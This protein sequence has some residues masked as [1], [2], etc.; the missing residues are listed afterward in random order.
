MEGIELFNR[1]TEEK[2]KI[3]EIGHKRI[4]GREGGVEVVVE[5]ISK[6]LVAKGYKV[7]VYD[8]SGNHVSGAEFNK[9]AEKEDYGIN[10]I[11]IP[12]IQKKGFAA[13]VYSLIASVYASCKGY[14]VIHYHSEGPCAFLWIPSLFGIRTVAT[15]HGLDWQRTGKWGSFAS[16]FIK[17][18]EKVAVKYADEIIVLSKQVQEYFMTTYNRK[19]NFIPNGVNRPDPLIANRITEKWG[20]ERDKYI[21]CLSRLTP[22]KGLHYAI[23]AFR[24]IKTDK[25]LVIAGG[26]SDSD[27]YVQRLKKLSQNDDRIIFTG[28]VRGD[29]LAELY[30]NAYL[31]CLPS[32]L[33]GMPLSLLE[34]MSYG[35]CCL[36]SDIPECTS[37]IAENGRTFA[38]GNVEELQKALENLINHPEIVDD[39]K[40]KSANYICEKYKWDD[41]VDKT[42]RLYKGETL[43]VH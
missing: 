24:N 1:V 39:Y 18:G 5:E 38:Q 17:F 40:K 2:L 13:L 27:E 32:D 22:E 25:K 8:R 3:A 33:E 35:N 36:V 23:E 42:I 28:F 30:S 21:L 43:N 6:R 34:A 4:F 26:A 7:D 14:D 31:Y 10:I 9:S 29:D 20:L 15:I 11:T 16:R 37:V 19:T 41:V 12:T